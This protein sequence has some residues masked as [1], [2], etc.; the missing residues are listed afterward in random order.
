MVVCKLCDL[1]AC[2]EKKTK[3]EF[4]V[5]SFEKFA[6]FKGDVFDFLKSWQ[7]QVNATETVNDFVIVSNSLFDKTVKITV[8]CGTE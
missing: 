2:L 6:T 8:L 7:Y 1:C 4:D 5:C 3:I